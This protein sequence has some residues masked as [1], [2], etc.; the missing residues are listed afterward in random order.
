[1][2]GIRNLHVVW[3]L[4][5]LVW[6]AAPPKV[7]SAE[8]VG[9][10]QR[11]LL[12]LPA[13]VKKGASFTIECQSGQST[14]GWAAK[15]LGQGVEHTLTIT[16]TQYDGT[17]GVWSLTAQVPTSITPELFDLVVT[18]SDVAD[19][20]K[21]AV[22]VIEAP[23]NSYTI[24]HITDSHLDRRANLDYNT[25]TEFLKIVEEINLINPEFVIHTGDLTEEAA[26]E[27]Y[28][29]VA[30][31]AL[32]RFEVPVFVTAGGHD[33]QVFQDNSEN[34][35]WWEKYF[36]KTMDFS[37]QYGNH[38]YVGLQEWEL[39]TQ[40]FTTEQL[41][42]A[43]NVLSQSVTRGDP[44][45]VLFY[46]YDVQNQIDANFVN[47][48]D[49]ELL[50]WGHE[51]TNSETIIGNGTHS[52][53]T[54]A[55]MDGGFGS[56]EYNGE[57]RLLRFENDQLVWTKVIRYNQLQI[58]YSPI[59]NGTNPEITATIV[60]N[61]TVEFPGARVRF[62]VPSA[63]APYTVN[64]GTVAF[65]R[66]AGTGIKL[67]AVDVTIPASSTV[68]VT[69]APQAGLT[70]HPPRIT[71]S[72]PEQ[73]FS[74]KSGQSQAFSV[75]ATD[76]D[77][78]NLLYT[79]YLNGVAQTNTGSSFTFTANNTHLGS[80]V[81]QVAVTDNQFADIY[82][83]QVTV[84]EQDL[85][86]AIIPHPLGLLP[87][88][89]EVT[90]SW[91]EVISLDCYFRFGTSPGD[92]T[93]GSIPE[94]GT[95]RSV[96]FI[97]QNVGMA[98]PGIYYGIITNSPDATISADE[99]ASSEF[100]IIIEAQNAPDVIAPLGTVTDPTPVFQWQPVDGVPYYH[101]VVSD[102]PV[103]ITEDA[104]GQTTVKG[105]NIIWQAITPNTSI[106]YGDVDPSGFFNATN[107][108]P[109][110][111]MTGLTYN[112]MVLNNYGNHPAFTSE[113]QGSVNEFVV[114]IPS[115]LSP[116]KLVAPADSSLI[117]GETIT[118]QWDEVPGAVNYKVSVFEQKTENGSTVSFPVWETTTSNTLV[119][120]PAGSY[121][122]N[123][124]YIWKVL[125][126]DEAGGG[127]QSENFMFSYATTVATLK[128]RTKT[129]SGAYL[130][131]VEVTVTPIEG[132]ADIVPLVTDN[133]GYA[134][135]VLRDGTYQLTARKDGYET[136]T[137]DA[138][139][140][141]DPY[142]DSPDGDT[143]VEI[144]LPESPASITGRAYNVATGV[145]VANATVI[146]TNTTSGDQKTVSTD[147]DGNFLIGVSSGTWDVY[148]K[149]TGYLASATQTVTV[150]AGSSVNLGANAL[151]LTLNQGTLSGVVKTTTGKAL[152]GATVT[153]YT[154]SDTVI[155]KTAANGS[156]QF[157]LTGGTWTV[158]AEK[159]GYVSP[160]PQSKTVP[161]N[162]VATADFS[163]TARANLVT[164]Y[165]TD[166]NK[167]IPN[168]TVTATPDAGTPVST[169][170]NNLG[171]YS[172]SLGSGTFTLSASKSG[173]T[174]QA[175]V[176]VSLTVGETVSGVDFTLVP[177]PSSIS[178][179]VTT[180]GVNGVAGATVTNGTVSAVTTSTGNFT[181]SLPEG[182]HTLYATKPGYATSES[183]V[184]TLLPGQALTGLEFR[185]TPNAAT[186]TGTITGN[187]LP[188]FQA[189]IT[190]SGDNG[191]FQTTTNEQGQYSISLSPG[192]YNISATK[193]GYLDATPQ[194]VVA[195]P[196]QTVPDIDFQLVLNKATL[197]GVVKNQAGDLLRNVTITAVNVNDAQDQNSTTTNVSGEYTL[198]VTAGKAYK[199]VAGKNGYA[200]AEA[201]LGTLAAGS[202]TTQNFTLTSLPSS[203]AGTVR[204]TKGNALADV[205]IHAGQDS[206]QTN[207]LG[208]YV[209]Y[210][211]AGSYDVSAAK[212][213]YDTGQQTVQINPGQNLTGVDFQLAD[214]LASVRGSVN[215]ATAPLEGVL[216]Q[217]SGSQGSAT[218]TT[219][220]QGKFFLDNLVPGTY[221]L[222]LS[223]SG[224]A[225]K[226]TTLVLGKK[227][228]L[229]LA[230]QLNR[231]TGTISGRVTAEGQPLADATI[232]AS[233][234]EGSYTALSDPFGNFV[235]TGLPKT[236]YTLSAVKS[237]YSQPAAIANVI[238][239]SNG[240]NFD[241]IPNK[242]RLAGV[243]KDG[244][245]V[246]ENVQINI[247]G[248]A[249]NTG[250]ATTG[251]S[252]VFVIENLAAD[253]Y[254][255]EATR[256]GFTMV[257][258]S[259]VVVLPPGGSDSVVVALKP[260]SL[261]I[262]GT[263]Q[264]AGQGLANVTVELL[265]N[266]ISQTTKTDAD[267]KFN[268]GGLQ[269]DQTYTVRTNIFKTGY[270]E[271]DTVV[272][273]GLQN[274]SNLVLSVVVV[275]GEIFGNVGTASASI[276]AEH[277]D[278][279]TFSAISNSEGNYRITELPAGTY[280]VHATKN[281]YVT[282]PA[283]QQVTLTATGKQEVNFTLSA[284]T[285]SIAG[286]V[287]NTTGEPLAGVS[288]TAV[289]DGNAPVTAATDSSGSYAMRDLPAGRTY[290][291]IA[292]LDGY[293][294]DPAQR[295]VTVQ[296]H[297][298]AAANFVLA[299]N[300]GTIK[301]RVVAQGGLALDKALVS[302]K[303]QDT[304]QS[305]STWS[306]TDGRF[307][308]QSLAAGQYLVSV[309]KGGYASE[310]DSLVTLGEGA[311]VE[312]T[313]TMESQTGAIRGFVR[314]RGRGLNQISVVA[315]GPTEMSVKTGNDGA[316]R[317]GALPA[318]NYDLRA[319]KPGFPP[320]VLPGIEVQKDS[321]QLLPLDFPGGR[322][323][324][325]FTDGAQPV[326]GVKIKVTPPKSQ[327]II[328]REAGREVFRGEI[329]DQSNIE[330]AMQSSPDGR[331]ATDSLRLAGVYHVSI[332]KEGYLIPKPE[333]LVVD[334][335]LDEFKTV[336]VPLVFRHDP[337]A[338]ANARDSIRIVMAY[339][340]GLPAERV[341]SPQLW[342]K[343]I[344]AEAFT[345]KPMT[346]TEDGWEAW[347]LPHNQS[348]KVEYYLTAVYDNNGEPWEYVSDSHTI[349]VNSK[350]ILYQVR[351]SPGN[352]VLQQGARVKLA[353]RPMDD[354]GAN[355]AS[356][357]ES[358]GQ[359]QWELASGDST[360][361]LEVDGQDPFRAYLWPEIE[362]QVK[363]R[364]KTT[365]DGL[366]K[367]G[368]AVFTSKKMELAGIDIQAPV[369]ASNS[370]PI[371]L[372]FIATSTDS[373]SMRLDSEWR[374]DPPYAGQVSE[375]GLFLPSDDFLGD[376]TV[377]LVDLTSQKEASVTI[378]LVASVD[379]TTEKTFVDGTGLRLS[380]EKNSVRR[381]RQISLIRPTLADVKKYTRDYQVVGGVYQLLPVGATFEKAPKLSLPRVQ[382]QL[383]GE[384]TLGWWEQTRLQW[385]PI[386]S[387][388]SDSAVSAFIEAFAQFAV[389]VGNEPLGIHGLSFLP[390]PFSPK[391]GVLRIGYV[392]TSDVGR[393]LVSIRIYNMRGDLVRTLLDRQVQFPGPHT[394]LS[395]AW[396]GTT[397]DGRLAR[398]GRYLVEVIA[399]D[400][401][402]KVRK[403]E[404][405]V[406]IK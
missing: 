195:N 100:Q 246:L 57:Y 53:S 54:G 321:E 331:V 191:S 329:I 146:A 192:T 55:T 50:L 140:A 115:N 193:S 369:Q 111:L 277:A 214:N 315:S 235:L 76:S 91:D 381:R 228:S 66:D 332:S 283:Q 59:N 96:K 165:V 132:S 346:A 97:P 174:N 42:W 318:G 156:Y 137:V 14:T 328:I 98:N 366:T 143:I 184:I 374:V 68:T 265:G 56:Y 351:I 311:T 397:D 353:A 285:G 205:V 359:V 378:N 301:G 123:S 17:A 288:V 31:D 403:V 225:D 5:S 335:G 64:G 394:E 293:S 348:G 92:Y 363:V 405:I 86:Y 263:V 155:T 274:V 307:E 125:A 282:S 131:R 36:G 167:S 338:S 197:S 364:V 173:Y 330:L 255:L 118:F 352:G 322:I 250:F 326:P 302:V 190:A 406:L 367:I 47:T 291:V 44:M 3:F 252:G 2:K 19:T 389:L 109:P 181:L 399:E 295:Q 164:G 105:A 278:G 261:S 20:A 11:P 147:A 116:P 341:T 376:V 317:F 248:K 264:A 276:T 43:Q 286:T 268:F 226:D 130:P 82:T 112:F 141:V 251:A 161:A 136:T 201:T 243:V 229:D 368:Q 345:A 60:N 391:R 124:T 266:N 210:L 18:A 259:I 297:Q 247:K 203:I 390:S 372:S 401:S 46:H 120:F 280:T 102:Q 157:T 27:R 135:K 85:P 333:H 67:I 388:V 61:N 325:I 176:Q 284:N 198:K 144:V 209:L 152:Q 337:V 347:I 371:Q 87:P 290:T 256:Q 357:V 216:V 106:R 63:F 183:Q 37:F 272:Q 382:T 33:L 127:V 232:T 79:W 342:V 170:T 133:T 169:T 15:L 386:Q 194:Q 178:G 400:V 74:M 186:I 387:V 234:P 395:L 304:G 40:S 213:G 35:T 26:Q 30:Q 166:G 227:A 80:N 199:L 88:A 70:N 392:L 230:L 45:R 180:D 163:L 72:S 320:I 202:A 1:M 151:G 275:A 257:Q 175:D 187:G 404:T 240:L 34:R 10:I 253:T 273:L 360:G 398:N 182:T 93:L 138:V 383:S 84:V 4:A 99:Y 148:A 379:S 298:T 219:N 249:G 260:I 25:L 179:R 162:G 90:L 349:N 271:A 139:L 134:I 75:T 129:T 49:L 29:Q 23:K 41:Q 117:T 221:Q 48:N 245:L 142:P 327:S 231:L 385:Q 323:E 113:V 58:S 365:L 39:P 292:E 215:S 393:A 242:A 267:G 355:L 306:G 309:S 289:S 77:G 237:G 73:F 107:G 238:P 177:N 358:R 222:S 279:R 189:T 149:K 121:L 12:N 108:T 38:V 168:A 9:A 204:D 122:I 158:K 69:I 24:V 262:A 305:K 373:Q 185:I 324:W 78:D 270:T 308:F 6:M 128:V 119:D 296:K 224:Y 396:D 287:R 344:G 375:N 7:Q 200:T 299:K 150:E 153:A 28:F 81:I 65:E 83:W 223:L 303:N 370:E 101:I 13:I 236:A 402:G 233:S 188:V 313:L 294:A 196:G 244:D 300:T 8:P 172:L 62:Y 220:L 218:A 16:D 206:T 269:P 207:H 104:N 110:P 281:G 350:G 89:T 334:L 361:R 159:T 336:T 95:S 340:K 21:H 241:L 208:N 384:P 160:S 94:D 316:F 354:T 32:S 380:F 52:I 314:Y 254:T 258:D 356:A 71:S 126:W 343:R 51:H 103:E 362:G 319:E 171:Q 217:L 22:K 312:L 377:T 211:S 239:D 154:G 310:G 114:D 145:G 339:T 212:A